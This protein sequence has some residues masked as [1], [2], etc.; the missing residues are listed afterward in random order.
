MKLS[1]SNI[2]CVCSSLVQWSVR[3]SQIGRLTHLLYRW[4]KYSVNLSNYDFALFR[5]WGKFSHLFNQCIRTITRRYAFTQHLA[6]ILVFICL[7]P[8][9]HGVQPLNMYNPSPLFSQNSLQFTQ[10]DD[11]YSGWTITHV[12]TKQ[13]ETAFI[14]NFAP[15]W[16]QL[17]FN[18]NLSKSLLNTP[19]LTP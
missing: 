10:E 11:V 14:F 2:W 19:L 12:S 1:S 15:N 5:I 13:R 4:K 7:Q 17:S 8:W 6:G 9:Y 16:R 3:L 18:C